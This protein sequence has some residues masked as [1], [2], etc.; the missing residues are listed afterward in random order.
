MKNHIMLITYADS[1]G[2]NIK[3]L[4]ELLNTY[5][6]SEIGA[7]HLLPFF[8]STGDRGFAPVSYEEVDPQFG[9][10]AD[11]EV[12]AGKYELMF[13]FMINHISKS[14][15]EF[16]DYVKYHDNSEYKDMFIAYKDFWPLG[17]PS[18]QDIDLLNKRKPYAPAVEVEFNDGLKERVWCTF[19]DE[20]IDINLKYEITWQFIEKSI[21]SLVR[22]GMS[23][24]RLD[25]FAFAIKKYGTSCFFVEPDMWEAMNRVRALLSKYNISVLPEIHDHYTVQM[26]IAKRGYPIYDFA[27]PVLMLHTLY[28]GNGRKIKKWLKDSPDWQYTTLDTHDGLGVVDVEDLLSQDEIQ[29]VLKQCKKYGATF[30]MD[31]SEKALENPVVYQI[32]CS[33]YSALG[34]NDKAYLLARAI[35][36]FAPG[37][38]QIYYLGLIAEPNNYELPKKTGNPRDISR[39]NYSFSEVSSLI[40]KPVVQ[41][42]KKLMRIRN[43][44]D[45]FNTTPCIRDSEDSILEI[46]R[47]GPNG[48][49][50]L[51]ANLKTYDFSITCTNSEYNYVQKG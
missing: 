51:V 29:H 14:S 31:F 3:K 16:K 32:D 43:E 21:R 40:K 19:S 27:L 35:Q 25:A 2:G 41:E 34:E 39:K 4:T 6:S 17:E 1:F 20:Q 12:L 48:E 44:F 13:D 24:M 5:F 38:P 33:Y 9:T 49:A 26:Q 7:V 18:Q 22:H 50:L 46:V 37:I 8:P 10:W 30:K 23:F 47:T 36:F 11:I 28:S 15:K 42:L 45:V